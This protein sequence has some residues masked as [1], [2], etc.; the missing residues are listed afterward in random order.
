[1][2]IFDLFQ[3]SLDSL[4]RNKMRTILTTLGIFMGALA[5][6]ATLQIKTTSNT[7]ILQRL[8]AREAPHLRV[9]TSYST[10]EDIEYLKQELDKIQAISAIM[11]HGNAERAI[12]RDRQTNIRLSAIS[13]EY[14]LATGRQ[15]LSNLGRPFLADDFQNYRNSLIIDTI[16]RDRLFGSENP[17]NQVVYINGMPY[18]IVGVMESK[19]EQFE[20]EEPVS[21]FIVPISTHMAL[22]NQ[23]EIEE[24]MIRPYN[25]ER[26][27]QLKP[28]IKTL[29]K[30]KHPELKELV[31]GDYPYVYSNIEDILAD[32]EIVRLATHSLLAAGIISL[33]VAGVGIANI[34]IASVLERTPELGLR[35]AIGARKQ[36]I[37][38]QI[39]LEAILVSSLGGFSAIVSVGGVT[40]LLTQQENLDLPTYAFNIENIL[41]SL[42]AAIATGVGSSLIPAIRASQVE[43]VKALQN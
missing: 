33:I 42:T 5:V 36:Q 18:R 40:F 37:L 15:I 14:F 19:Q 35:R 26:M 7:K 34:T 4:G 2:K 31:F 20:A 13:E 3:M 1:M 21:E 9:W 8:S 29:L 10:L 41:V 24:F 11:T 28:Q 30:Q 39:L 23:R 6:N 43:P 22:T 12:Y 17:I 38:L 25:I 16:G 32:R 27:E